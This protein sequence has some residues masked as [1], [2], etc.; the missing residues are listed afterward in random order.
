MTKSDISPGRYLKR[1]VTFILDCLAYLALAVLLY[2]LYMMQ[3]IWGVDKAILKERSSPALLQHHVEMLSV[4]LPHRAP[5]PDLIEPTAQYIYAELSRF[6][7]DVSFKNFEVDGE[8]FKN[9]IARFGP[10]SDQSPVY[11]IG[12]H[13]DSEHG[14]PGADDNA[15]GV[16]GLLEL[17]RLFSQ[18]PPQVPVELAAYVLEEPPYFRTKSMGSFQHAKS[19]LDNN[20]EVALMISLEMLGYY[21]DDPNSQKYPLPGMNLLYPDSGNFIALVGRL[22]DPFIMRKYK[23]AFTH[24]TDLPV[25]SMNAPALLPGVDFSDHLNF[26]RFDFPAIMITDTA[27]YRNPHYHKS[28]DTPDTLD[29]E[30]MAKAVDGVFGSIIFSE[31]FS[32]F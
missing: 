32:P 22:S 16:A 11:I 17:A 23:K 24:S 1:F 28:S 18:R 4:K 31:A 14:N 27:F 15:S 9:I 3:P 25:Y 29:F 30:R 13:Y 19:L 2:V 26:W 7:D 8:T 6:S 10:R 20:R 5:V 21:S 12:A